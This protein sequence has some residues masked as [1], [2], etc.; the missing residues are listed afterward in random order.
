VKTKS[1]SKKV[2]IV[3]ALV[4]AGT[5]AYGYGVGHWFEKKASTEL[6]G[7][8]V[9]RGPLRISVVQRGN[10]AAKDSVSVESEIEG[11]TTVL[12]LIAEGTFVKPD[13]LLVELDAS[14]LVEKKRQQEI[15]VQNAE[16]AYVK[17]KAQFEIQES[18]NLSD[19][20][21]ADRKLSFAELDKK[22]YLEGDRIQ[23]IDQAQDKILLAESKRKQA[24]NT[25]EWSEKLLEKGYVTKSDMERDQLDFESARVQLKEANSAKDLLEQ[26][27]DRRK[28]IELDANVEEAKR[29]LERTKLRAEATIV[30]FE[31]GRNTSK[32]RLELEEQRLKKWLD[33]IAK[34]RIV[35]KWSGM[36]VYSRVE[37]GR[38]GMG[39]PI[40]KGS[41]VRERQE[42]LT[43]PRTGG[44]IA[45]ASIHESVLK[46]VLPDLPCT[47]SIDAMP[48]QSFTG[49]V[50]FVALLP[51]K[52]SWWANPNQRLYKTEITLDEVNPEMG[53]GMSC[54][55]EILT[56]EIP[57]ALF[58]PL[59]SILTQKGDTIAFVS[60]G[61]EIEQ[62]KV[63]VG[64]NNDKW[65]EVSDGLKEGET[66]LLSP[67]PGFVPEGK[68]QGEPIGPAG[69]RHGAGDRTRRADGTPSTSAPAARAGIAGE[70]KGAGE[71][72]SSETA[73]TN[74]TSG[75]ASNVAGGASKATGGVTD[76]TSSRPAVAQ[77]EA[78]SGTPR[79]RAGDARSRPPAAELGQ[80]RGAD[81]ARDRV[82]E[83][84]AKESSS[85][86]RASEK[87]S[88][89]AT[90]AAH[91]TQR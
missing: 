10:L 88:A 86:D 39:E 12:F 70:Q 15:A 72:R 34:A 25:K 43:I 28:K 65:V 77:D 7:A 48:G 85:V 3:L 63:K 4:S 91:G 59:L 54:N 19:V 76:S 33:Q 81:G 20:E 9:R 64:R 62:R 2:W 24:E 89:A 45:E 52:G 55:I 27:E 75:A 73:A 30:D 78:T 51:D 37:S 79:D 67:P 56:Q 40:Q 5:L 31:A 6:R 74:P 53:P 46:Q 90:G 38:M 32:A 36:V 29:G 1:K 47:L 18:Q 23:L 87:S 17:A 60:N 11:Q 80:K 61:D 16:A 68:E 42:I 83:G 41:Q 13:D 69:D 49:R 22:K 58:V 50:H 21:A 71:P 82:Q 35:S 14:D 57:D 44:M 66:V 84:A 8:P 26:Y